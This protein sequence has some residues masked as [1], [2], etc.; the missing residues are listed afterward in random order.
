VFSDRRRKGGV[1]D[2]QLALGVGGGSKARIGLGNC[3]GATDLAWRDTVETGLPFRD[4][5][6]DLLFG[7]RTGAGKELR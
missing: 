7:R 1:R 5:R 3:T 6:P 2:A 4:P